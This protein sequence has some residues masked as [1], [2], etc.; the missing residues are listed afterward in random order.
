M[1]TGLIVLPIFL[2]AGIGCSDAAKAK[3]RAEVEAEAARAAQAKAESELARVKDEANLAKVK[4]HQ[5]EN[6]GRLELV[7]PRPVAPA[8]GSLLDVFPRKTTLRWTPL[9]GAASYKIEVEYQ[10]PSTGKWL[11][12]FAPKVTGPTEREL[13][14]VGAQPGRWR[15]WAVDNNGREGPKSDWWTFRYT[16]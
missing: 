5:V 9:D 13:D 15:V 1:R 4:A 6:P 10:D 16:Q 8:N 3:A 2:I 7:A 14:F 11:P 12:H